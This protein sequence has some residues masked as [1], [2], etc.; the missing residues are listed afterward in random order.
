MEMSIA[1]MATAQKAA[2]IE[3]A[4][5]VAV[6]KMAQDAGEAEAVALINAMPQAPSMSGVG[7]SVDVSV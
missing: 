6:L 5:S 7:E 2:E 4:V 1:N 3:N